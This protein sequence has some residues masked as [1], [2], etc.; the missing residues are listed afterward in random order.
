MNGPEREWYK[1]TLGV[2]HVPEEVER[3][4]EFPPVALPPWEHF[5]ALRSYV[6]GITN[7]GITNMISKSYT[8][9]D[10]ED[11]PFGFNA[12]M[13]KQVMDA[14]N[15]TAPNAFNAM[16]V[17]V[18]EHLRETT[19]PDWLRSRFKILDKRFNFSGLACR[20][21]DPEFALELMIAGGTEKMF[22]DCPNVA[23]NAIKISPPELLSRLATHNNTKV[24]YYVGKNAITPEPLEILA[25]DKNIAVRKQVAKNPHTLPETLT[26]LAT[27][28]RSEVRSEVPWNNAAL[29]ILANLANNDFT[30]RVNVA[31]NDD[32]PPE[33]LSRLAMDNNRMVQRMVARN[34]NTPP[35]V[36]ASIL[37]RDR[38]ARRETTKEL[39]EKF[40][41]MAVVGDP[42]VVA[43]NRETPTV[44]LE[45]LAKSNID[46]INRSLAKNPSAP[47][48]MIFEFLFNFDQETRANAEGNLQQMG[49]I[50]LD[51]LEDIYAIRNRMLLEWAKKTNKYFGGGKITLGITNAHNEFRGEY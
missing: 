32:T 12:A 8:M 35:E 46:W 50:T 36:V 40:K 24:R 2:M 9:G 25:R 27:D 3:M 39:L 42:A 15:K 33:V 31:A 10:P 26:D 38:Q 7:T 17:K 30:V 51:E 28:A 4:Q 5:K 21:R 22:S 19:P 41:R 1:L 49:E 13:Q 45:S 48:Q 43:A 16:K 11:L 6:M 44:V 37:E 18:F 47:P 29:P 34:K 23:I 14:I 20:L